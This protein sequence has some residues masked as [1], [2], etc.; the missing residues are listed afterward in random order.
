[1]IVDFKTDF[2][3]NED[4]L[5]AIVDKGHRKQITRYKSAVEFLMHETPRAQLCYLDYQGGVRW[6]TIEP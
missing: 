2:L 1:V 3:T 6:V 5:Q 4:D